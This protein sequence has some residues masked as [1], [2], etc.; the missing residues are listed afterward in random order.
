MGLRP[1]PATLQALT[2]FVL[3]DAGLR[4]FGFNRVYRWIVTAAAGR[5]PEEAPAEARQRVVEAVNGATRLYYRRRRDCLPKALATFFLLR[6]RRI[7]AALVLG[8]KK[9]PF[10][11]HAWVESQGEVIDDVPERVARYSVISRAS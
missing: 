9:F 8:V 5:A 7:P 6:R 2:V 3:I 4:L 10:A 1:Q 11:A